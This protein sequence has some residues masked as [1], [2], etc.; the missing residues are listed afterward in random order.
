MYDEL[1][2]EIIYYAVENMAVDGSSF[3]YQDTAYRMDGTELGTVKEASEEAKANGEVLS[4]TDADAGECYALK[5]GGR[6]LCK[7]HIR[8]GD[9]SGKKAL[10]ESPGLLSG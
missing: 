5:E 2:Y 1:G 6:D 10:D 3:D 4:V 9:D 7:Y 8:N